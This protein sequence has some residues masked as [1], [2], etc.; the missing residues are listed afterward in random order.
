[1]NT[2]GQPETFGGIFNAEDGF[3]LAAVP[4]GEKWNR[5]SNSLV[6]VMVDRGASGHYFGVALIP[7]LMFRLDNYQELTI[8]RWITT[9]GGH[10]LDGAGQGLLWGHI[11]DAEGVLHLI[12][13]PV[14]IAPGLGRNLFSVK[15][16]SRNGVVQ[17]STN[18]TQGWRQRTSRFDSK[19]LRMTYTSFRWTFLMGAARRCSQ[20]KRRLPPPS[21]IGGWCTSTG[22]VW[23]S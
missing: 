14:L 2:N 13:I 15:Q 17:S 19:S 12:Q 21:G 8:R 16:V 3:A 20:C 10:Q 11:I 9:A 6:S 22:R 4:A 7:R 1:M 23:S 18:T 5:G